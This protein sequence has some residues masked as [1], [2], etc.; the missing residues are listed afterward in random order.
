MTGTAPPIRRC[1]PALALAL[2]LGAAAPAQ[3]QARTL[4]RAGDYIVAVVNTESVTAVEVEQR[5]AR[6]LVEARRS[7]AVLPGEAEL[8][9]Q[10][11]DALIEER[12]LLT[13]A[14]ESGA[15][16]D[17]V[18]LDRAVSAVA[19]QNQ[20]SVEQLRRRLAEDG[21]DY[22]RF[23]GNLR[24]QMMLERVRERE[25]ASRIR[26][27]DAEIDRM[28][29]SRRASAEGDQELELAQI[30]VAVPEGASEAVVA[31]RRARAERAL[32][33]VRAGENFATVAREVSEDANRSDGGAIGRR[34]ARRLPDLFVE[35]TRGLAAGQLAPQPVR[36]AAGFHVLKVIDRSASPGVT[37]TQTLARHVLL[38]VSE[39]APAP[40]LARRL[41][42][43][44]GQI[45]RGE[46]S[47]EE[48]AREISEDGSAAAG[49]E[50]GWAS[51]G[52]FVPE[53][54]QAMNRL[55]PKGISPPVQSRFGL[56]L[57]QVVDRREVTIDAKELR[58]Q[59][60]NLLREQKFE[61]AYL[62][63]TKDLR[64]RAYIEM[65]EPPI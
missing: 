38:R 12:V 37:V 59:A 63:W 60:R 39:R 61:Q 9:Q 51:P 28:I 50:L 6:A 42:Q 24:D 11:L 44:R 40:V 46:R 36:S 23:R 34:P 48:V 53:F 27:S 5:L 3:A 16:I 64:Q 1:L 65:R 47:F 4:P 20:L 25:V 21:I 35:A 8:R 18:E 54:E 13:H 7:G 33:R 15:R 31:E 26:I 43:L 55:A 22:M 62:D 17:E 41:E 14:R 30:L 19:A 56:H 10:V 52:Q 45:E 29:E 58:E 49:G 57:I 32:A 2:L